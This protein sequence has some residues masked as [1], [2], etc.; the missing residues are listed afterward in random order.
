MR[1]YGK[2]EK[3]VSEVIG[4]ILILG[5]TV[6][7]FSSIF[8]Y[9]AVMPP[10]K[11]QV[12]TSFTSNYEIY[13]NGTF[14]ITITNS[15]GESLSIYTT[16]LIV[17]VQNPN[18]HIMHYLSYSKIYNQIK[19]NYFKVGKSFYYDSYWDGIHNATY[20]ST[21]SIYLIDTQNNQV[22]WSNVL[23]GAISTVKIIGFSYTPDPMPANATFLAHFTSFIIYNVNDKVLP[24]V[25][26]TIPKFGIKG[27]MSYVFPM[28]YS[29]TQTI[30]GLPPGQYPIYINATMGNITDHYYGL[31]Q[32]ANTGLSLIALKVTS[33]SLQNPEPVHGSNTTIFI[34]IYNPSNRTETFQLNI[35]DHF[36]SYPNGW[37]YIYTTP[38]KLDDPTSYFSIGPMTS[39]PITIPWYK[40]GGS[41]VAAGLHK[42]NVSFINVT[43]YIANSGNSVNI[44]I[45]PKIIFVGDDFSMSSSSNVYN[46]YYWLFKY[47]NFPISITSPTPSSSIFV[48]ISGY[49][50]VIWVMGSSSATLGP[51]L[52]ELDNLLSQGGS[53]LFIGNGTSNFAGLSGIGTG[54]LSSESLLK[55]ATVRYQNLTKISPN[56]FN[57]TINYTANITAGQYVLFSSGNKDLANLSGSASDIA[58]TYGVVNNSN[59]HGKFVYIGYQLSSMFLYQQYYVMNKIIMWLSNVTLLSGVQ[60]IA[61]VDMSVSNSNPMFMQ[62]VNFTFYIQNF[63][64]GTFGPTYLEFE[65]NSQIVPVIQGNVNI[66]SNNIYVPPLP[67]NGAVTPITIT[68]YADISPGTYQIFADVNPYH[69][70]PEINY[71]N[72][73]L[74]GMINVNL[75]VKFSILVVYVHSSSEK[76]NNITGVLNAL[77]NT[78]GKG[79][80]KFVNYY[81]QNSNTVITNVKNLS[82]TFKNY[83]LVIIDVNNS[84]KF[85]S[86]LA[87]AINSYINNPNT[88]KYPYSMI[89]LG[90]NFKNAIS[91]YPSIKSILNIS[92]VNTGSR[93]SIG[94]LYGLTYDNLNLNL[95]PLGANVSRGYGLV[96]NYGTGAGAVSTVINLKSNVAGT[97]IFDVNNYTSSL[98]NRTGNAVIENLSNVIVTI[99]PYDFENIVGF[100]QN[101]TIQYAPTNPVQYAKN[102][103]MMNFL[104]ASRYLFN[105][106]LPEILS[107]DISINSNNVTLNNYY[108][109]TVTMRNLGA[110]STYVTLEAFEETSMFYSSQPIYLVG[111]TMNSITTVTATVIWKPSYA[112]SPNPE[113]IR[114]VLVPSNSNVQVSPMLEALTSITVYYFYDNG[115]S[116][117]G[118]NHYNV[119][120][121]ITGENLFG[122]YKANS[123][124]YI[125]WASSENGTTDPYPYNGYIP[126]YGITNSSYFSYPN[127]TWIQDIINKNRFSGSYSYVYLALPQ[128]TVTSNSVVTLSW[129]WKYS[130]AE[131]Q[132]GIFLM[133]DIQ[134]SNP[135]WYQVDLPYNNNPD[136]GN[137]VRISDPFNRSN[138]YAYIYQV[139]NGVSGGGTYSWEY[140]NINTNNLCVMNPKTGLPMPNPLNVVGEKIR[141]VFYYIAPD[142]EANS[143]SGS[144]IPGNGTYIDNVLLSITNGGKDGW[145]T[146]VPG[147]KSTYYGISSSGKSYLGFA[148]S[149]TYS[150]IACYDNNSGYPSF[151][152]SLW[153][154]LITPP[155][156]LI[157]SLTASLI[158]TFKANLAQGWYGDGWPGDYFALS[159]SENNGVTWSQIYSPPTY[160]T[161]P[162]PS[163]S[164]S[165]NSGQSGGGTIYYTGSSFLPANG[166]NQTYWLS[167]TL[168]LNFFV[169]QNILLNFQ[170]ITNNGWSNGWPGGSSLFIPWHA[171]GYN[172]PSANP[173]LGF[174]MTNIHVQGYSLYSPIQVQTVWT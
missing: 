74:S 28:E 127:S 145:R 151:K 95:G 109:F 23:Q 63:S 88:Y 54:T 126:E 16:E 142:I 124:I 107:A 173:F 32:V 79:N 69:D 128:V 37:S 50:F 78:V 60:D 171:V 85:D 101:H 48:N 132:N 15:G 117:A 68:W 57:E 143:I 58:A 8:Y 80:Y 116:L 169:G 21:I 123:G 158:F 86:N 138:N 73:I 45:Y 121:Y 130:I 19:N 11:S 72:N 65:I 5:I 120:A 172:D 75:N 77:N 33:I 7:L 4:T 44:T 110:V 66:P 41:Y 98:P 141:F 26:I 154:N 90:Q 56:S 1:K 38:T 157:N 83:N 137:I 67:G 13:P 84:G 99:F 29:F 104:V 114:F 159:I 47:M 55:N 163:S 131:A 27:N 81:E 34:S 112:S 17:M 39:L 108:L 70:P 148:G 102:F 10:P 174:Y 12:Y 9:V 22:V 152:N 115:S 125:N 92:S 149:P 139:F 40:I 62:P 155:I 52:P 168:P 36:S 103:L 93:T 146:I 6:V 31:I 118:W 94:Y 20:L 164:S 42:L 170:I 119:I 14:N 53:L 3:G 46:D 144:D 105:K 165:S 89:F 166:A 76:N 71:N 87:Y 122:L 162:T 59:N 140:Y 167:I 153:D 161:P 35:T 2:K 113:W 106:P 96:Y 51:N 160:P 150:L 136:L 91:N 147:Q 100:V 82:A 24:K 156:D 30:S 134:G 135:G 133:V 61:L 64:P 18:D 25:N 111:S 97:A 129:Y 43:P 49:D